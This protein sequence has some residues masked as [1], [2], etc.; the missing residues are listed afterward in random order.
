MNSTLNGARGKLP[1]TSRIDTLSDLLT[2]SA[3]YS[4]IDSPYAARTFTAVGI[5][6][7]GYVMKAII[8][9]C[10]A[11]GLLLT[12]PVWARPMVGGCPM[13]PADSVWNTPVDHAPVAANSAALI[14]SIG[15]GGHVH[16]D[17]GSNPG[18][19]LPYTTVSQ[20]QTT[21]P[22]AFE[23]DDESDPGPY[24]VPLDAPIES[25]GDRHVLVV[26]KG[27]CELYEL[28]LATPNTSSW[29]AYAGA[30]FDLISNQLRPDGWT[31]SDAAGLPLLPLLARY[32]EVAAGKIEHALRFTVKNTRDAHIWPA[33]HDASRSSDPSLPPMGLRLRLRADYPE[34]GLSQSARVIVVA[35]KRYGMFLAD[36]GSNWYITGATDTRWNDDAVG[37]LK[38]IRGDDFQVVD[39]SGLMVHPDSAEARVFASGFDN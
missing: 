25:G 2:R 34:E 6:P 24:P 36:N 23:Y 32:D 19:G 15:A 1:T 22:M 28:Y 3:R 8:S 38:A 30:R 18:Y 5:G 14:A 12:M 21:Y 29:H 17:F 37:Q 7:P 4:R 13:F 11:L 33:R 10:F 20:N 35:L 27:V 26:Q 16:P 39:E 9:I 31:S